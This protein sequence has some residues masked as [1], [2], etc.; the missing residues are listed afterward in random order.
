MALMGDP[1][2]DFTIIGIGK[3]TSKLNKY[4]SVDNMR[5]SPQMPKRL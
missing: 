5:V 4:S 2:P 3:E 1:D